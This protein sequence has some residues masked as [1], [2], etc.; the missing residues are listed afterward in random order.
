MLRFS[1]QLC[2]Y[3]ALLLPTCLS[4][5]RNLRSHEIEAETDDE[6]Q[7]LIIGEDRRETT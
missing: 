7:S 5:E 2:S 3:L 6:D 1:F 4:W